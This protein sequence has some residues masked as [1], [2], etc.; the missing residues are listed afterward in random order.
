MRYLTIAGRQVSVV[1]LGAWQFGSKSWGWGTEFDTDEAYAIVNRALELGITL[2]DTAEIYGNGL[3][4]SILGQAL[5]SR[6]SEAYVATKLWPSHG[7]R[8]QVAATVRRS[9]SRLAMDHVELYQVHWPNPLMPLSWTMAGMRDVREA[10]LVNEVG[11]SNFGLRR[12]RR[13]DDA[14][15]A[16]VISNQV[17]YNLLRRQPEDDLIPFAQTNDRMV[18]A[19]SPLAQGL[20][21]GRYSSSNL[22]GG[23]RRFNSLFTSEN[24]R[25][26]KP[27]LEALQQIAHAHRVTPAQIALAWIVRQPAVAAIPGAKSVWQVE[28]NAEAADIDLTEDEL[29]G[30]DNVSRAFHPVNRLRGWK[31]LMRRLIAG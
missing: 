19:Y 24:I 28:Q 14:L 3:S 9:L 1:G 5:G 10:G 21:S 12:W 25:R 15:G 26:A 16:P 30:L 11:V 20:L 17:S 27:V 13:A 4:E 6:R 2:F 7:L 23:F 29:G 22:P 18:L 8:R 31:P